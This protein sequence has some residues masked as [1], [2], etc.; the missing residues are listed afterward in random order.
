MS[1]G[2]PIYSHAARKGECGLDL[3]SHIISGEY[4]WLFKRNHQE[5]D[6]GIDAQVDVVLE[7]GNVTGQIFALQIKYGTSFFDEKNKWGYIYRGEKKHFNYLSNYP[8]PVLI[9]I[10]HPEERECYW[11]QFDPQTTSSA[12][13][14]WK[15]TIPFEN[16]L[17]GSK[18]VITSS[19]LPPP[20][21]YWSGVEDYWAINDII[22]KHNYFLYVI[23]RE[24]VEKLDVSDVR[25][26]FDRLRSNQEI[27]EHCLGKIEISFQ[28]YDEDIRELFEIPEVCKFVPLLS[29]ALP[30]L[31]FFAY[32]GAKGH[33]LMTIAMCLASAKRLSTVSENKISVEISTKKIRS[34]L[35]DHW[36]GLNEMT[37]W[38]KMSIEENKEISFNIVRALGFKP[39]I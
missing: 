12:G 15:I 5:H 32:T 16:K 17:S 8:I 7:N 36:L 30:E 3:V 2:F 18:T 23:S 37:E 24:E 31:F 14:N 22:V 29:M 4:G 11:V 26:F 25:K 33:G 10:C 28:G 35:N 20:A 34:F 9:V 38:L 21:D 6:F 27:A 39:P 1:Q 19:I 13:K